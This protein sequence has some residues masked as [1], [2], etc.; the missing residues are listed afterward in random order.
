M[1]V[2]S[3]QDIAGRWSLHRRV[4]NN[5]KLQTHLQNAWN[6]YGADA[7]EFIIFENDIPFEDLLSWEQ[8]AFEYYEPEY[9]V[10]KFA[11]SPL[12]ITR[13]PETR[14]KMSRHQIGAGNH[15]YGKKA[16]PE[17]RAK[18]SEARKGE[19]C[20][21]F[22]KTRSPELRAKLSEAKKGLEIKATQGEKHWNAKLTAIQVK[23]IK[24]LLEEK[25]SS[26][27]KIANIYKVS[28]AQIGY[29]KTGKRWKHI[30]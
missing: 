16:S 2:G 9:N 23:K 1:Y 30:I 26:Q 11:G 24:K 17:T 13:S 21:L 25:E 10:H 5:N 4:L 28:R 8:A 3:S 12:G 20:Y 7:F 27:Q 6:K 29:I 18:L 22:G 19:K 14:A 15:N